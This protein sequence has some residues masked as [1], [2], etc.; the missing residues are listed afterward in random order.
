M[1]TNPEP[2]IVT[3]DFDLPFPVHISGEPISVDVRGANCSLKFE[4]IT[5]EDIDPRLRLGDTDFDLAEDRF[6][7]V[8]YS[9]AIVSI[10]LEQIPPLPSGV[11]QDEWPVE[12][13]IS[14]VND[15]LGHYR[16]LL[17]IPWIRRMDPTE[18][19]ASD[20]LN[21]TG[22]HW[23]AFEAQTG[24]SVIDTQI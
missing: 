6:G 16:D 17:N 22:Q 7:W 19:W 2:D 8:R 9:R 20:E 23:Y 10:P 4:T 14:A 18:I 24:F 1:E 21:Q 5:R 13:A 11:K 3:V 15:L 12:I